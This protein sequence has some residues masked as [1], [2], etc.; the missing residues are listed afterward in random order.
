MPDQFNFFAA[1]KRT[2]SNWKINAIW[3][4]KKNI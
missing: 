1:A 3:S 2:W 4:K